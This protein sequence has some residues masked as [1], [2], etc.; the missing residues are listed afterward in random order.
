MSKEDSAM[1]P[2]R[3]ESTMMMNKSTARSYLAALLLVALPLSVP[4]VTALPDAELSIEPSAARFAQVTFGQ[5]GTPVSFVV[6]NQGTSTRTLYQ[7]SLGGS[8][9]A[10]YQIGTDTCSTT[11]L[12]A[13]ASC[14]VEVSFVPASSG[15]KAAF[16]LVPSDDSDT[17]TLSAFLSNFEDS[18]SEATRRLPPIL[19]ASNLPATLA[20]GQSMTLT[21]SLYGYDED[22]LSS[23]VVFN[24]TG[25]VDCGASYSATKFVD[26][27]LLTP[28]SSGVGPW[29]FDSA[30]SQRYDYS[31]TFT[32][33]VVTQLTETVVRFYVKSAADKAAGYTSLSL[34]VPGNVDG[35]GAYFYDDAGRRLKVMIQP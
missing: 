18:L 20:S 25:Q 10:E 1:E 11:L 29:S 22:H 26:S 34:L 27:G 9:A 19:S 21:W 16:L 24:C 2:T 13:G 33:P 15:A 5:A 23:V 8:N 14:T 30:Q 7:A 17:P 32:A 12:S 6:R 31:Y 28:V 4:A 3:N 35:L